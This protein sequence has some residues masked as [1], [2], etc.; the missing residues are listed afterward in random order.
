MAED[1][2][3]RLTGAFPAT[4]TGTRDPRTPVV[5]PVRMRFQSFVDFIETQSMNMSRTGIFLV[6]REVLAVGTILDLELTLV[7]GF[8]LLRGKGEVMRVSTNPPG[9]GVK[10]R[11]LD[12]TSQRLLEKIVEVNIQEGKR[13][14]VSLDFNEPA[15]SGV[16]RAAT[17]ITAGIVF[18][19]RD[20]RLQ[21]NP[22]T[23]G[24]FTNNPLLNIRLG[25]FVV[26]GAEDVPLGT[27]FNVTIEDA[28]GAP[29]W[30]GKGKVVAKHEVRL[31]IRLTDVPKDAL[32]RLQAEVTRA[33]PGK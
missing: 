3:H 26:P 4:A 31:G 15:T 21:I 13:S 30:T 27:I 7:D 12:E 24:F 18:S 8:P 29:L 32:Q 9:V 22:G 19:G 16:R 28:S 11:Q 33:A 5:V 2:S 14:T 17:G 23:S 6:T 10:F 25:G 1:R 20:L